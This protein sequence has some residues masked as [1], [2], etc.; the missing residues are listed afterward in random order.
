LFMNAGDVISIDVRDSRDGLRVRLD[1]LTSDGSGS[2]TASSDNGFQQ[3]IFDPNAATCSSRPYD[4]HPMYSTSSE[5]TRVPWA[6]HS[7]NVAFSDEI[8]HFEYCPHVHSADGSNDLG[9]FVCD[10]GPTASDPAGSDAD[11]QDGNC[12]PA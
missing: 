10:K 12:A 5:H 9:T 3:I 4:F 6:A 2:M 7:Y 8:G 1:D 11:D